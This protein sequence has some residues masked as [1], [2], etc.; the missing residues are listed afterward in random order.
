MLDIGADF[1]NGACGLS[2]IGGKLIPNGFHQIGVG[3]DRPHRGADFLNGF[4]EVF[5]HIS[6]FIVS[7]HRQ[8]NRQIAFTLRDVF[9]GAN[10]NI[11]RLYHCAGNKVYGNQRS[12]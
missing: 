3:A 1:V 7:M 2:H 10:N 8:P 5:S 4:I 11:D 12:Q 6:H 9:E